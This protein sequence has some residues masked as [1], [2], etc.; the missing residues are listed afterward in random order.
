MPGIHGRLKASGVLVAALGCQSPAR[1]AD[2]ALPGNSVAADELNLVE[3]SVPW[4]D[5]LHPDVVTAPITL[6]DDGHLVLG[7]VFDATDRAL[8]SIHLATGRTVRFARR[9]RGPG[10]VR[11]VGGLFASGNA[12][13]VQESGESQFIRFTASGEHVWTVRS[14]PPVV[15]LAVRGDSIDELGGGLAGVVIRRRHLRAD[16]GRTLHSPADS[17]WRAWRGEGLRPQPVGYATFADGRM[18]MLNP[19]TY[20]IQYYDQSGTPTFRTRRELEPRLPTSREIERFS[21]HL[22]QNRGRPFYGPDG[23]PV[24]IGGRPSEADQL[25][26]YQERILPHFHGLEGVWTDAGD[27][28]WVVGQANDSTWVDLFEDHAFVRRWT[29]PCTG[30]DRWLR[31][32]M[33]GGFLAFVCEVDDPAGEIAARVRIYRIIGNSN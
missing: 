28:L 4:V 26:A 13:I 11:L 19:F 15:V 22:A 6:T 32:A 10:E 33:G 18:V 21:E 3:V 30:T 17:T 16:T 9:G 20:E 2:L 7:A 27:R 5:S 1:E 23:R 29:L 12:V 14:W 31:A 25:H 8:V 24:D